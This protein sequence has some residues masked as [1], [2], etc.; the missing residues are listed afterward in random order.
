MHLESA[1]I[2]EFETQKLNLPDPAFLTYQ[3][4]FPKMIGLKKEFGHYPNILVI[5]HGGSVTS[6]MGFYGALGSEK[7]V[8]FLSTVDPDYISALKAKLPKEQTLVIAISKSGE[9]VTQIEGLLQFADYPLLFI[10]SK[11]SVLYKIGEKLNAK[12]LLHP[13]IGGRFIGFT[14]VALAPA[15]IAGID[16]EALYK[17]AMEMYKKYHEDNI[18]LK[19]AQIVYALE[20]KG[21]VDVFMP[22]YSHELFALSNLVVQLCHESFGKDGKG[23]TY[24]AVEAPE[25]QH[26]T[27]QRFF[28]GRKNIA[29]FF[30]TLDRFKNVLQ[31]SVPHGLQNIAVK[32][33]SLFELHKM[34]LAFAM[35]SEFRG[36][37][38][39]AKIHDIPILSLSVDAI[40]PEE[41]GKFTAFW[42]LFTLYSSVLRNVD[43]FN[44]PQVENSKNISWTKRKDFKRT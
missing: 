25:S 36:T 32:D 20:Q 11:D 35:H 13:A 37:W 42:Q 6:L 38:E 41:I 40:T 26:H 39:D 3:P 2:P 18:A 19:A 16:V 23:Q 28:G 8:Q 22:F 4:Q 9:N 34:P 5:G 43:P 15:A 31:T 27:N 17:G 12:I 44:Q 7:N 24:L 14:E 1:N 29:G 21:F 30:V 10:T 33:S